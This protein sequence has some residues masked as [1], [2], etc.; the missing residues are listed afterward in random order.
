MSPVFRARAWRNQ[1]QTKPEP[2]KQSKPYAN[3]LIAYHKAFMLSSA[4]GSVS[5]STSSPFIAQQQA[6]TQAF[7]SLLGLRLY[8]ACVTVL[9]SLTQPSSPS[10]CSFHL[11]TELKGLL[12]LPFQNFKLAANCEYNFSRMTSY[13]VVISLVSRYEEL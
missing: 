8:Q 5:V 1:A 7:D 3:P 13:E 12:G 10:L 6:R 9:T 4:G 2:T 11:Y